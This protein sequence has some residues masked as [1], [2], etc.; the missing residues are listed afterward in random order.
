MKEKI[1]KITITSI[2]VTGCTWGA[3]KDE[4]RSPVKYLGNGEYIYDFKYTKDCLYGDHI[5]VCAKEKIELLNLVPMACRNGI[6]VFSKGGPNNG[7][8]FAKFRCK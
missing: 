3:P 1:I 8:V 5:K 4:D 7:W 6:D 2:L